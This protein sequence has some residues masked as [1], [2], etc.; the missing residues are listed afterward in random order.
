MLFENYFFPFMKEVAL[1]RNIHRT[2]SVV[3]KEDV[4]LMVV[5]KYVF[6]QVCSEIYEKEMAE[7]IEFCR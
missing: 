1:L 7:K 5:D 6:A 3:V 2:A 4:E